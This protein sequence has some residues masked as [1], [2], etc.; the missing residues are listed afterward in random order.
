MSTSEFNNK[1]IAAIYYSEL[2]FTDRVY[3]DTQSE[4][5]N[6]IYNLLKKT[7]KKNREENYIEIYF[8]HNN[9]NEKLEDT[10]SFVITWDRRKDYENPKI[11]FT[12]EFGRYSKK[13]SR[14]F[15]FPVKID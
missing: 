15:F 3:F 8:G 11:S 4:C 9:E 10:T 5:L 6:Y 2:G 13:E 7:Q 12:M 14:H 1:W